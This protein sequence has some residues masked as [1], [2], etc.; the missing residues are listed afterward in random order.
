MVTLL[1]LISKIGDVRFMEGFNSLRGRCG[2][3]N[4]KGYSVPLHTNLIF[5][6]ISLFLLLYVKYAPVNMNGTLQISLYFLSNF[7]Y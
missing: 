1:V 4:D 5:T 3:V 2:S 7:L 6:F